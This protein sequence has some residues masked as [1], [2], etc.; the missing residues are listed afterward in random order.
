M[1]KAHG[2]GAVSNC[3]VGFDYHLVTGPL[4][5]EG[6]CTHAR[7]LAYM[8]NIRWIFVGYLECAFLQAYIYIWVVST[9]KN[10]MPSFSGVSIFEILTFG[11]FLVIPY[12]NLLIITQKY[13]NKRPTSVLCQENPWLWAP[14]TKKKAKFRV[15]VSELN[16][17][18]KH[19]MVFSFGFVL[20]KLSLVLAFVFWFW[21][22]FSPSFFILYFFL[23]FWLGF[24]WS[25]GL[26]FHISVF[27]FFFLLIRVFFFSTSFV[28]YFWA[29][30][31][32][33]KFKH[34]FTL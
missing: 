7:A 21:C 17:R 28:L 12:R 31:F 29:N 24:S 25:Q 9:S 3:K 11:C 18:F 19:N 6:K 30:G 13:I 4:L 10:V 22:F 23:H 32:L 2:W 33:F 15:R 26:L 16:L 1:G 14:W 27:F 5:W 34:L 20:F 8:L